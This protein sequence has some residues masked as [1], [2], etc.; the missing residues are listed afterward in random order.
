MPNKFGGPNIRIPPAF[1][2][3]G[4][5]IGLWLESIYPIQFVARSASPRSWGT[6]G[7]AIAIL[8]LIFSF[9]GILTFQR[10]HTPMFPYGT[11]KRVVQNGPYRFTR[12]PMYVGGAIT[13]V[14]IALAMNVIWPIV[15]LPLVLWSLFVFVISEEEKYLGELFGDDYAAYK[16][17]VR[18]WI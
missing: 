6:A 13:Y 3:A 11:A 14:G 2:V 4:F 18:R 5:L 16:R 7:W 17:R 1:F 8:G 10:A 12:N 15:L 9:W